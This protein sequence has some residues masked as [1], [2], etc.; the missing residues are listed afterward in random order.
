MARCADPHGSSVRAS[1]RV[2]LAAAIVA[3]CALISQSPAAA[4]AAKSTTTSASA[5]P[6]EAPSSAHS[7]RAE[8]AA[9]VESAPAPLVAAPL[10][11]PPEAPSGAR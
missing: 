10:P 7:R 9:G 6:S 2:L 5:P 1:T 11:A 8:R 3:C 4:L